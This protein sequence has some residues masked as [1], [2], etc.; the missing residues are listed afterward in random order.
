MLDGNDEPLVGLM[1]M[2][3]AAEALGAQFLQVNVAAPS[4]ESR[5]EAVETACDAV[6]VNGLSL[7]IE[8]LPFTPLATLAETLDIVDAVGSGRAGALVDIWHH[9]H[10]PDGWAV[11]AQAPLRSIAYV[12]FCDALPAV[13][14]DLMVETI[15]RRT[16][17]GEGTLEVARFADLLRER[18]HTGMV[19]VDILN[20]AYLQQPAGQFVERCHSSA[21]RYWA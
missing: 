9:S 21:V 15:E 10:D 13:S 20:R 19:S 1:E 14:T 12:E 4:P 2:A 7:A 18:C 8:Y 11:L 6:H 16:F 17:P 5:R 3:R